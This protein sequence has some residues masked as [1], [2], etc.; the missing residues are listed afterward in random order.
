MIMKKSLKT[1]LVTAVLMLLA[2]APVH[3]QDKPNLSIIWFAWP[4]CDLLSSVVAD[5]EA[6]NVTVTCVPIGE[7]RNQIFA[8][9]A[10]QGGADL[11]IL[12]SQFMGEAVKGGF[13]ED[14]TDVIK[15]DLPFDDYN[16]TALSAYAEVPIG[17]GTYYSV[18]VITDTRMMV[19]RKDLFED[20]AVQEAYKAATGND[21]AVP[22]TWTELLAIAE[23]F[24][25]SDTIDAGYVSHWINDGDLV[26][27]A[28]NHIL[29]SFGG[30]LWDP[31]TYQVEG[32]LNS[33]TNV[34]A[35][36][37]AQKLFATGP[38][39]AAAFGF[40]EVVDAICSGSTA[41][42]EIWYGFGGAFTDPATCANAENLGFAVAPAEVAHFISLGGQGISV[43]KFSQNKE[44][45]LDFIKWLQSDET[46]TKWVEGGGFSGRT[47]ILA[48]DAF[49][50]A[51]PYNPTFAEAFQYVK[52]FWNLPE[53]AAMLSVQGEYLNLAISGQMDAKEALD[54][55]AAEQ[56]EIIDE[57]YPDGAPAMA[58]TEAQ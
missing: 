20:P 48:S 35:L 9:F 50:N 7:W 16:Q 39:G 15:N 47:S 17:S 2:I 57:A 23:F 27:T 31:A 40:T 6:A 21:L 41:M 10:A 26:Q 8:D 42:V 24:K 11:P 58:T 38:E 33:E 32:V 22:T 36:E 13:I 1:I 30:E 3:P 55:I 14:L 52:D 18:P 25:N 34:K 44:A 4:P 54:E 12:D 51:A 53:Y 49:L 29:W 28:F 56:Q 37:F 5:Y 19:Y 43:S 45:A 46:Q